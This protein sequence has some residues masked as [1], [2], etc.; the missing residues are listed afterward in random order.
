[1]PNPTGERTEWHGQNEA[2][3]LTGR[4]TFMTPLAGSDEPNAPSRH[5]V[6]LLMS[7]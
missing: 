2:Q 5:R 4:L 6:I 7:S 1:M 3:G